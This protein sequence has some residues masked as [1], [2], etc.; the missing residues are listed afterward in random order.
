MKTKQKILAF[1]IS[2]SCVFTACY[3]ETLKIE[4]SPFLFENEVH[5]IDIKPNDERFDISQYID[6]VVYVKLEL[7]DESIIGNIEKVLVFENCIYVMDGQTSSL[8]MFDMEGNYLSKICKIGNG[9]GEYTRLDFFN[10]DVEKRHIVLTDLMSYWNIRYDMNGN[11]LSRKKIPVNT[12][13][14]APLA[15]E[16]YISFSNFRNNKRFFEQEYNLVY[17]DSLMQ[18]QKAYFPYNSSVLYDPFVQFSIIP[19][20]PF[21]TYSNELY[22]HYKMKNEIYRVSPEGVSLKYKFNID[23][24]NFDYS[25][26]NKKNNLMEY[27]NDGKYWTIYNVCE[28]HDILFLSFSENTYPKAFMCYYSKLSGKS[29]NS[30]AFTLSK[31]NFSGIPIASSNEWFICELSVDNLLDYKNFVDK[32][33]NSFQEQGYK[34]ERDL[35][36]EHPALI[37]RKRLAD[38]LTLDDNSVLM[39]YKLKSF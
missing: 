29:I 37:E 10:I 28:T 6:S 33:N 32:V 35:F 27:V 31:F 19:C 2:S 18:I 20:G 15:K 30:S 39:F 11:Y 16:Q 7:T 26:I 8:F 5:S 14:F 17:L 9:P 12:E 38:K 13:G 1:L 23:N 24:N 36:L 34:G 4:E 22:F 21:Y 3:Q 25:R